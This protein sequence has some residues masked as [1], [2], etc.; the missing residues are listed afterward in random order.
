MK[1]LDGIF[2]PLGAAG[3]YTARQRKRPK[4]PRG[5]KNSESGKS[6]GKKELCSRPMKVDPEYSTSKSTTQEVQ[7]YESELI[8]TSVRR[9][10]H[11]RCLQVF[12]ACS[13]EMVGLETA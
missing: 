13:N 10:A 3:K 2:D 9:K 6:K 7:D 1:W 5:L 11:D 8:R 12:L 4:S